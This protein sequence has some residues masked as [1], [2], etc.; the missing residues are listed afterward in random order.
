MPNLNRQAD[1]GRASCRAQDNAI[2]DRPMVVLLAA[3]GVMLHEARARAR[4]S[5]PG[6]GALAQLVLILADGRF[7]EREA[8][9][10]AVQVAAH[11]R[12]ARGPHAPQCTH[13]QGFLHFH[14]GQAHAL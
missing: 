12:N 7:H 3:L 13:G 14:F 2:A 11:P 10:R 6:G 8:L 1:K 9:R 5:G 4:A